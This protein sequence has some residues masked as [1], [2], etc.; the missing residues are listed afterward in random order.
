MILMKD[1]NSIKQLYNYCKTS[2]EYRTISR[3]SKEDVREYGVHVMGAGDLGVERIFFGCITLHTDDLGPS[4]KYQLLVPRWIKKGY[5]L[6]LMTPSVRI[7]LENNVP[8][9]FNNTKPHCILPSTSKVSYR[10]LRKNAN[11]WGYV[12]E[13]YYA[14]LVGMKNK[15][16]NQILVK[17]LGFFVANKF[18]RDWIINNTETRVAL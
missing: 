18:E 9:L 13:D 5:E 10:V 4:E 16:C 17:S 6:D 2:G 12:S 7:K 3:F 15:M 14:Y 1:D 11:K 8:I